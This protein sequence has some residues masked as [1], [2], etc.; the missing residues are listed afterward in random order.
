MTT[1]DPPTF[2]CRAGTFAVRVTDE[3]LA[4]LSLKWGCDVAAAWQGDD[5]D[6]VLVRLQDPA[7]LAGAVGGACSLQLLARGIGS[8]EFG[9]A[10]AEGAAA[11]RARRALVAALAV[12][13]PDAPGTRA[14][15][16][17]WGIPNDL[18]GG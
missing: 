7:E 2:A 4:V 6:P 15:L 12:R 11:R 5:P 9:R 17:L 18:L 8:T 14:A 10:L 3:L 1:A 16:A 13:F